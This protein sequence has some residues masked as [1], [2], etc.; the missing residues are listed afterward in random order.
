MNNRMDPAFIE[1]IRNTTRIL[2]KPY[3]GIVS[4][5][6]KLPYILIGPDSL[7]VKNSVEIRGRIHV[8]P[9]LIL[10]ANP[11]NPTFGEMFGD[12][13]IDKQLTAR[14][15]SFFYSNRYS[16][17]KIQN[18]DLKINRCEDSAPDK[19]SSVMDD[20]LKR[21]IVDTAVI[22]CPNIEYYPISLERFI[23]EIIEREFNI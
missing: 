4:G 12:E 20:L 2:R 18:E 9:K 7:N 13:L 1:Q 3:T 19:E 21:E 8:S 5:Y 10:T 17:L 11:S 16:N 22:G 6:H 23:K 14:M 15:F